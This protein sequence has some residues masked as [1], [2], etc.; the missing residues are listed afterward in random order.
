MNAIN[1]NGG[2]SV[3]TGS[4]NTGLTGN[5]AIGQAASELFSY[6]VMA[7][8]TVMQTSNRSGIRG[9]GAGM[10]YLG[11]ALGSGVAQGIQNYGKIVKNQFKVIDNQVYYF[12]VNGK[13]L[14][15]FQ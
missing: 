8:G 9:L 15:I 12:D 13:W 4:Y 6:P 11:G 14:S 10:S 2:T 3:T 5:Y 7:A 1:G